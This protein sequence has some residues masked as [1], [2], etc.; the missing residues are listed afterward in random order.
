VPVGANRIETFPVEEETEVVALVGNLARGEDAQPRRGGGRNPS[1]RPDYSAASSA[2]TTGCA[3]VEDLRITGGNLR[4]AAVESYG[5]HRT[6]MAL[7]VAGLFAEGITRIRD[8]ECVAK[9][10]PGFFESLKQLS[11]PATVTI[12]PSP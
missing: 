5:D 6:A 12:E 3:D 10:F 7:A 1:Y 2:V 11:G 8:V 4:G 9:S